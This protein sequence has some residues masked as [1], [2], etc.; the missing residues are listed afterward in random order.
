MDIPGTIAAY[1][2]FNHSDF[3]KLKSKLKVEYDLDIILYYKKVERDFEV[4]F[5]IFLLH[6]SSL[7][8]NSY[9]EA[10][11]AIIKLFTQHQVGNT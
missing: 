3:N 8:I 9:N 7:S 5:C 2:L 1:N 6:P 10:K 4:D 11:N